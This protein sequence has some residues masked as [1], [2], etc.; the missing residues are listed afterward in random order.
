MQAGLSSEQLAQLWEVAQS[1]GV[2]PTVTRDR[3]GDSLVI[4]EDWRDVCKVAGLIPSVATA[5]QLEQ[6]PATAISGDYPHIDYFVGDYSFSDEYGTCAHCGVAIYTEDMQPDHYCDGDQGFYMCGDCLRANK[7]F[8]DDYLSYCA[9]HLEDDPGCAYE[10]MANPADHGFLC[11]NPDSG[12]LIAREDNPADHPGFPHWLSYGNHDDFKR[13][14]KAA[15][16]IDPNLQ[17]VCSYE[18]ASGGV[19]R[20]WARFNPNEAL[21]IPAHQSWGNWGEVDYTP[22]LPGIDQ[23]LGYVCGLVFDKFRKLSGVK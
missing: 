2:Y 5:E 21:I 20:I 10:R 14:G 17:V 16:L 9:Y 18:H 8:A 7:D 23:M 22:E 11:L 19:V 13:L 1:A 3:W 12:E 4:F 15:R 6:Y